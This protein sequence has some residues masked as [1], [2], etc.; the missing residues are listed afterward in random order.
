MDIY[1]KDK[2]QKLKRGVG[3][4]KGSGAHEFTDKQIQQIYTMAGLGF[5]IENISRVMNVSIST[6][7]RLRHKNSGIQE[8]ILKGRDIANMNV[9]TNL[10]KMATDRENTQA[11]IFWM[12][13][14][15]GWN[16]RSQIDLNVKQEVIFAT[17]IGPDGVLRKVAEEKQELEGELLEA[18]YSSLPTESVDASDD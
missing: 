4:P 7:H 8:A 12:R 18:A 15:A 11:A 13:A 14:R 3:R 6:L 16:D 9:A 2:N 1:L 10:Y 5:G 17:R